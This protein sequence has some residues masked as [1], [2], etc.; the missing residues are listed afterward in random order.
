MKV[1]NEYIDIDKLTK[2]IYDDKTMIKMRGNGI[3]L[4][5]EEV[6]VLK[7]YS[8]DYNKYSSI[9]SLIFEIER[10]LNEQPDLDELEEISKR[11]AEFNYYNNTNK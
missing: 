7:K 5:D 10:I 3:Y 9:S 11:L 6:E 1:N 2:N 4:S 8:I